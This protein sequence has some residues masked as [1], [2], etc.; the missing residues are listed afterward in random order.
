VDDAELARR[1][2]LGF[3]E[4]LA[5]L[6]RWGVGPDVV[7]RRSDALGARIDVAADN[8]WFSAAVVPYD[9]APPA[10][11][12]RLPHC[13]WTV[14][15]SVPGR[16]EQVEIATPCMG[17]V[18]DDLALRLKDGLPNLEVPSL[19]VVGDVNERAYGDTGGPFG[20]LVGAVRDDRICTHGL[21]A[22]GAFVCVALTLRVGDDLS[23]Q[24]VATDEEHRR[25][26]LASQLLLAVMA[27]AHREGIRTATLQA[28]PDGLSVYERLG[29]RRVATI[30]GY[31]RPEPST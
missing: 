20:S 14:A 1:S 30:R 5:A 21:R 3:G 19:A 6:G 10:D 23:I 2:I 7:V 22:D 16:V 9:A 25:R 24:Y 18:L 27:D 31:V 28:S 15:D 4:M 8:P 17:V 11:E 12:P 29:F 26:G 13:I